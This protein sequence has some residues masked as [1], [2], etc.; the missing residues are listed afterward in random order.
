MTSVSLL[1]SR[2]HESER[3]AQMARLNLTWAIGAC[4]GPAL[5]LRGA[6]AWGT[7]AVLLGVAA[8]FGLAAGLVLAA[9]PHV[10]VMPAIAP[11]VRAKKPMVVLLLMVPLATGVESAAGGWLA[12]YSKRSGETLGEVIGVATCFWVGMLVS[13]LIQSHRRV[14]TASVLSRFV[15]GPWVMSAAVGILLISSG[16]VSILAGA[17]LLGL[18]IGPM[19]PLLLA[20]ALR[21]GE[22]GNMV[23]VAAG[24]GASLLPL[25]TGLVS[26]W[27]G[28]LRAGLGVPLA[29]AVVMGCLGLAGWRSERAW[30]RQQ[31]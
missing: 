22:A 1:Q 7:P 15:V 23:F 31:P 25:L 11:T 16:G 8:F 21:R 24:C 9:V 4:L 28:S 5:E 12:T 30:S 29:G 17:L 6:A 26:G 19:Y 14:A 20:L 3:A 2:R 10:D 27:T 13:R 18:A